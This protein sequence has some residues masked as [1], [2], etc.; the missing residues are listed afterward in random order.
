M[1]SLFPAESHR[2]RRR[3]FVCWRM[4]TFRRAKRREGSLWG[5]LA[6]RSHVQQM[7]VLDRHLLNKINL[8]SEL[9]VKWASSQ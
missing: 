2:R 1:L 7:I 6:Y 9:A 8:V 4:L 5:S 3:S